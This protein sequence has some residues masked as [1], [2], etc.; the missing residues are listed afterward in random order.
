M[1]SGTEIVAIA[2]TYVG[3]PWHHTARLKTIGIDCTG[4]LVCVFR[5]AG[6]DIE[7]EVHYSLQDEYTLLQKYLDINTVKVS[8]ED[9]LPG[10]IVVFRARLMHNHVG[11]LT[12]EGTFIHAYNS[13]SVKRVV[14]QEYDNSWQMRAVEYRR[15]REDLW[16]Q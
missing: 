15:V 16:R 4:L 2:R 10:D 1:V 7:D 9:V 13:P 3:T 5:E 8:A 12:G 11:I 14:E 6:Y